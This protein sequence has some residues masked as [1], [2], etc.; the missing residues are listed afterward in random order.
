MP[1]SPPQKVFL[2]HSLHSFLMKK[3]SFHVLFGVYFIYFALFEYV[4]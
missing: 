4:L 3:W 2:D 1:L